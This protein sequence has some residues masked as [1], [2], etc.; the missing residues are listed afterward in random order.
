MKISFD[1]IKEYQERFMKLDHIE[2]DTVGDLFTHKELRELIGILG[3]LLFFMHMT[4]K[5]DLDI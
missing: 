1:K 4:H 5:E 3:N 2:F